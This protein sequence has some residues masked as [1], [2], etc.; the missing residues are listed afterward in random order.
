MSALRGFQNEII[1]DFD[2]RLP[3]CGQYWS[4][5]TTDSEKTVIATGFGASA[6]AAG[7]RILVLGH[8]TRT[9]RLPVTW[10]SFM[11]RRP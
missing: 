8:P 3:A 6:V 11:E 5:P 2:R 4:L 7:Q 1:D 10:A 9:R